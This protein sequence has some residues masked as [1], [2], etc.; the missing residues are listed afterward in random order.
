MAPQLPTLEQVLPLPDPIEGIVTADLID[1]NGH[2]NVVHYLNQNSEGA[3]A[4]V[5]NVGVDEAYRSE[6]RLG[7][8][9][10]EHHLVYYSELREGD[11][12]SVHAR[13]L[14]RTDKA[15]HMMTFLFD[16][17]R[18]RLSNTLEIMLVH[19]DLEARRATA[20]PENISAGFDRHISR[21]TELDWTA[22]ICGAIALRR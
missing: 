19:V 20:L 7:L 16:R 2:M 11:K 13:V 8:F 14:G 22:P 12:F 3:D 5:R 18:Q 1:S 9:T 4:L 21:S 15:V 6:R 10:T 17:S